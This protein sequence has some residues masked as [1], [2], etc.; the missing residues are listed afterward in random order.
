MLAL[1]SLFRQ[2]SSL[3][4]PSPKET[5]QN[6]VVDAAYQTIPS[7]PISSLAYVQESD[8]T[9]IS[10]YFR[11][12]WLQPLLDYSIPPQKVFR[13]ISAAEVP[14]NSAKL[15]IKPD[16]IVIVASGGYAGAGLDVSDTYDLPNAVTYWRTRGLAEGTLP[17]LTGGETIAYATYHFRNQQ[18][19]IPIPDLWMLLV[20]GFISRGIQLSPMLR[21]QKWF[22]FGAIV[23]YTGLSLQLYVAGGI[24]MPWSLPIVVWVGYG[25][26][27]IRGS[28]NV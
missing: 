12:Y 10:A 13:T 8:I 5:F 18:F 16:Q 17:K 23:G 9:F 3:P 20:V 21:N 26:P 11:Q 7:N 6:I 15:S 1:S 19:L 2:S 24:L 28:K 22:W 4:Q 25:L 27:F 14:D